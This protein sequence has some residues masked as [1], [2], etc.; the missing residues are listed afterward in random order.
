MQ[1]GIVIAIIFISIA[2]LATLTWLTVAMDRCANYKRRRA[3]AIRRRQ[4]Q[5][6]RAFKSGQGSTQLRL[7]DL[8]PPPRIPLPVLPQREH[9]QWIGSNAVHSSSGSVQ[10]DA[11]RNNLDRDFDDHFIITDE[12][13]T[14]DDVER[15]PSSEW[16]GPKSAGGKPSR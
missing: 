6:L 12:Y 16:P 8:P 13:D 11:R 7:S 1:A 15:G 4:N 9:K 3:Q 10:L 2:A 5:K 14:W